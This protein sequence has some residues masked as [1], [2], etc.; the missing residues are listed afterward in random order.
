MAATAT[1][2]AGVWLGSAAAAAGA[3]R[4]PDDRRKS[5]SRSLLREVYGSFVGDVGLFL[6]Y[7]RAGDRALLL[8]RALTKRR[9]ILA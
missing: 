8:V 4:A 7:L 3:G 9:K 2:G 5:V 6:A 1:V